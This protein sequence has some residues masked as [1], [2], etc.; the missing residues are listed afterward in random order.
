MPLEVT[1]TN[2]QKVPIGISPVTE[3]G[4]PVLLDGPVVVTV[5]SGD[6]SV[7][8]I[9]E[10]N[11]YVASGDALADSTFL[12]EGDADLGAGVISIADTIILH[13]EHAN[14]KSLGMVVGV[15]VLK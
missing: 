3:A 10:S 1:C 13:V 12:V 11:F 6:G 14:A 15:A 7:E 2:E 5:I 8:M 9:D 4:K